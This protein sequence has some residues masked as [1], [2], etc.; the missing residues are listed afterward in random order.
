VTV[1]AIYLDVLGIAFMLVPQKIGID[2]VPTDA[3]PAL[4]AYLHL[5]MTVAFV[6]AGRDALQSRA[7]S[8]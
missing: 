1:A 5:L 6:L 8:R 3:S 4:I 2:A 7:A